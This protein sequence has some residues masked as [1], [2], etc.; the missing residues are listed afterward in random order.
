M[1][2]AARRP[3]LGLPA[4]GSLVLHAAVGVALFVARPGRPPVLPPVYKVDLVA[5]PPGPRRAGVVT[6][7]PAAPEP[8]QPKA[9]PPPRPIE[10]PK[11]MPAPPKAAE[12]KPPPRKDPPAATPTPAPAKQPTKAPQQTAGG[13]PTGGRGTDVVTVHTQGIEFPYPGYLSNIVRQIAL[14][15]HEN[16]NVPVT[17]EVAFLIHRD[18]SISNFRFV[19]RS[20]A[21]AFDLEAQGAVEAAGSNRAFGPLPEGFPDDVLPVVFSFDPK[22]LR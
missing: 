7:R 12:R 6:P 5:A 3:G 2:S 17:A 21:Y 14:N 19:R 11:A 22:V 1:R 18:G 13:G 16:P 20:G 8:E 15:F 10:A 4:F 9:P